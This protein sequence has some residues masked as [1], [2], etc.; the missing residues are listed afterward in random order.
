M[1]EMTLKQW[2]MSQDLGLTDKDFGKWQS[3]LHVRSK[4]GVLR[5]LAQYRDKHNSYMRYT[6]FTSNIDGEF[7]V[8]IPFNYIPEESK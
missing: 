7:W 4:P 5:A 6:Q 8:E 3:D 2:L 1:K